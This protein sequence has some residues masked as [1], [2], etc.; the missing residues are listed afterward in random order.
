[1]ADDYLSDREQEEALLNWWREN[2]LWIVGGVVLAIAGV[3]G[4]NGY[5]A[6]QTRQAETGAG[7]YQQ[8]TTALSAQ[9]ETEAQRLLQELGSQYQRTPY[10][11]HARLMMARQHVEQGRLDEASTLLRQVADTASDAELAWIARLRAARVMIEQGRFDEAVQQLPVD[12]AGAFT[13]QA[14]EVRG[15]ALFAKGDTSGA[16]AEYAAALSADEG[17]DGG[18]GTLVDRELVQMK[19][20][21]LGTAVA[22]ADASA[23]T[24]PE[25]T[26]A[27]E[28]SSEPEAAAP[29]QEQ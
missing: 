12:R 3:F 21:D 18:A 4:W 5:Q 15:D 9:N 23:A 1:M 11:Q 17:L 6:S 14:R 25:A 13:A 29:A 19:M 26:A 7:L 28:E 16:R 2:W 27:D 8:F 24:A 10:A 20:Q 22:G